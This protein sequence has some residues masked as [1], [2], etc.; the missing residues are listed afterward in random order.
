MNKS[1]ISELKKRFKKTKVTASRLAGC[2]VAGEEREI[3]TYIN[4]TFLN[5]ED[6]EMFKYLEIMKKTMSGTLG[7]NLLELPF[8]TKEELEG[9]CYKSL[10][11]LRDSELKSEQMLEAFYRSVIDTYDYPGNYLI[12]LVFDAY[13]VPKQTQDGQLLDESEEVYKYILCA[14]CP[15][16]LTEPGLSYFEDR[17]VIANR[18]R[19]WLVEAPMN[20]FVFPAFTDRSA[21]VHNLLYYVKNTDEMH[22]ELIET[23][24]GCTSKEPYDKQ[25]KTLYN[26]VDSV[27]NDVPEYE[28]F[29]VVRNINDTLVEMVEE[30]EADEPVLLDCKGLK[31]VFRESGIKDEHLYAVEDAFKACVSDGNLDA[32]GLVEKS[33]KLKT[34]TVT[35]QVKPENADIIEVRVID[36]RK[37]LVIPMDVDIEVN[38]V[39]RRVREELENAAENADKEQ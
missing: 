22:H 2:Y 7:K 9:N 30:K 32:R 11:A 38:G 5:L 13:D 12:L 21:D 23:V 28:T 1:D 10:V 14:I 39:M 29:A 36:G 31:E 37:C 24:L 18:V 3:K 6:E 17:N 8:T 33:M 19:D 4:D 25:K 16:E 35:V 26:I 15:V 20:G 27:I 34:D